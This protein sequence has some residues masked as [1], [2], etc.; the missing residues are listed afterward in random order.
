MPSQIHEFLLSLFRHRADIT[1]ALLETLLQQKVPAY[2]EIKI[3]E[4]DLS[5]LT[6]TEYRADMVILLRRGGKNLLC[7]VLEVQLAIDKHKR[8]YVW[9]L[10]AAAAHAKF[11]CPTYVLVLTPSRGVARRRIRRCP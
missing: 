8:L 10:Y 1:P 6:P 9:P 5:Q 4:A 7:I 3:C 2:E 11:G